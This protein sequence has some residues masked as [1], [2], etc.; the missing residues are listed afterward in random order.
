MPE[1]FYY[2]TLDNKVSTA[3][4][5]KM[6]Q[7]LGP[8]TLCRAFSAEDQKGCRYWKEASYAKHCMYWREHI[9]GACDCVWAQRNLEKPKEE[10]PNVKG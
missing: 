5:I 1:Y 2:N 6:C 3:V 7:T 8:M 10:V 9:G 4:P